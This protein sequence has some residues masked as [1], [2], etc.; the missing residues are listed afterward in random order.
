MASGRRT[1]I[2]TRR[3]RSE[4]EKANPL[5]NQLWVSDRFHDQD[6]VK[7]AKY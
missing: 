7:N 3:N 1:G 5:K 6:S 2:F 4:R